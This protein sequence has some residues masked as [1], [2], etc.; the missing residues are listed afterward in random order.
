M[1]KLLNL[2]KSF[3]RLNENPDQIIIIND[4]STDKTTQLLNKW[5][6]KKHSFSA[7]VLEN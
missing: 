5:N 6:K 3:N 7:T 2:L 4:G 1:S